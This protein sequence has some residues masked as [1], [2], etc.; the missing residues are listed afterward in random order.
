MTREEFRNYLLDTLPGART[1]KGGSQIICI[2]PLCG[3]HSGHCYLGPFD[4]DTAPVMFNCFK[5][6]EGPHKSGIVNQNFMSRYN[7]W[8]PDG[9]STTPTSKDG[10]KAKLISGRKVLDLSTNYISDSQLNRN[11]LNYI[12]DR[13]GVRF[14]YHDIASLKLVLSLSDVLNGNAIS[15]YT[16][17][18][19]DMNTLDECFVGAVGV[20]NNIISLRNMIYSKDNNF[21]KR[22]LMGNKYVNYVVNNNMDYDKFYVV[23]TRLDTLKPVNIHVCEG[24]MDALGI[25]VNVLNGVSNNDVVIAGFGKSYSEA[26]KYIIMSYPFVSVNVHLYP[27]A[28]VTDRSVLN[29]VNEIA[30]FVEHV[31]CHRNAF[32]AQKDYGVPA[33]LIRDTCAKII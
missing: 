25:H 27:D 22:S 10:F 28:D 12:N 17:H 13:L 20:N 7:C 16:R 6:S 24:F 31:Y 4:D 26:V 23:P 2:C 21:D 9:F 14:T 8:M 11:K 5:C 29:T 30:P 18:I 1:A 3:D 32:P 15:K 19:N 33:A